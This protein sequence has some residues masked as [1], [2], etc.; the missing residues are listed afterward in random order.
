MQRDWRLFDNGVDLI[1]RRKKGVPKSWHSYVFIDIC[2]HLHINFFFV[3][4]VVAGKDICTVRAIAAF[5]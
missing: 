5:T 2:T 1:V 4:V 3:V